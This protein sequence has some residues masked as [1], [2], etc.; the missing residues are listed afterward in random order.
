MLNVHL[1]LIQL[2]DR[3]SDTRSQGYTNL[4]SLAKCLDHTDI[5]SD[6]VCSQLAPNLAG[7]SWESA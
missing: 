3:I 5:V 7:T 6:I 1:H 4:Q 2:V